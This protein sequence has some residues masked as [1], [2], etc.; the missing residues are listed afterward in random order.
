VQPDQASRRENRL[1]ECAT[2]Q[3]SPHRESPHI[4]HQCP[5]LHCRDHT[6]STFGSRVCCRRPKSTTDL[7]AKYPWTLSKASRGAQSSNHVSYH[8]DFA[9]KR[10][11]LHCESTPSSHQKTSTIPWHRHNQTS[12]RS[13]CNICHAKL[14]N[15]HS[16]VGPVLL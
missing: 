10:F 7:Q 8:T 4:F 14:T 1:D 6:R 3:T 12:H 9:Q 15:H 2:H 5:Y 13:P 16:T 11:L